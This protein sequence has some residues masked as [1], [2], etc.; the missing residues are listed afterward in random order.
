MA[1]NIL[2]LDIVGLDTLKTYCSCFVVAW[3]DT[4]L[5]RM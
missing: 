2:D 1:N 3:V 5:P 4:W